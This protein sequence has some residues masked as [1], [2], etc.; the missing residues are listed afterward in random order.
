[1]TKVKRVAAI[2]DLSGF[3]RCS[4]AVAM[5]ALSAMGAQCVAL[6]TAYL[7]A[8]TA[9]SGFTFFD[10][11]EQMV[12]AARHW[13]DMGL[14]FDALYS[15]FLG[16]ERQIDVVAGFF[17]TFKRGG[18]T[19][20]VVDPVMGDDGKPYKTYTPNMC[21]RMRE[22]A[23]KA[24]LITPNVTEACI[25]LNRPY[26]SLPS[27]T[28]DYEDWLRELSGGG[29]RSV[30]ITGVRPSPCKIG[31][32]CYDRD[33]GDCAYIGRSYVGRM[34]HGTGDLFSSV[35][36]GALMRGAPLADAVDL[37]AGFVHECCELSLADGTPPAEGVRFESL[38]G[39]LS[40]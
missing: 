11:T 34:F 15:G 26:E 12:E 2:H 36:V 7:S 23:D 10:M 3:G 28:E 8:N 27:R 38:L 29:A 40:P 4:L 39:K 6:P 17:D 24:D 18:D 21:S 20:V 32:V 37:A 25:L 16:S 22:L 19:M 30:V 1:M 35:T 5:P 13:E 31:Q 14:R 33:T 9:F